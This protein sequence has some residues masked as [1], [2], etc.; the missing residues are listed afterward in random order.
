MSWWWFWWFWHI[1]SHILTYSDIFWLSYM[2]FMCW[3]KNF[4][5]ATSRLR[6]RA[7][8]E[9]RAQ[10][11]GRKLCGA[12]NLPLG[13][14]GKWSI[15]DGKWW[16]L[17]FWGNVWT[18]KACRNHGTIYGFVWKWLVPLH[19]M[20]LLIIIP[21]KNGYHWGYTPFSDTP[22]SDGKLWSLIGAIW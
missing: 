17:V 8:L 4:S 13:E 6:P 3:N 14:I 12:L 19:P 9:R 15:S 2:A 10:R 11:L 22:I 21:M 20:V 16:S 5:P 18:G 7:S 1:H